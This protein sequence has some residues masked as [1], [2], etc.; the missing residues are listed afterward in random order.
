VAVR[1]RCASILLAA[2]LSTLGGAAR[3]QDAEGR[4]ELDPGALFRAANAALGAERPG[5]AIA[6]LEAL[7]DR[8]VVDAVVSFNRGLAYAARVRAGG[9]QPGD[10][11]RAAH[12][13]E[14]AREL[15]NDRALAADATSALAIV[16]SE[17]ARRRSRAGESV[18]IEHGFSLGRSIVEL[19]P[20]NV[21]AG[22]AAVMAL[23]LSAAILLRR[24]ATAPRAKVA[25]TTAASITGAL[26]LATAILAWAARDARLH[27]R[28][29]IVTTSGA[30]LLDARHL[31]M[32]GVPP[33]PE[34]VRARVLDESAGFS[35]VVIGRA[36]GYLPSSAVL[37]LAR[38]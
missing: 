17:I 33:I 6:K 7:G 1:R 20:E 5:E 35:R 28:E 18:E 25:A 37:P 8:G 15:T 14:E 19:L 26:L 11:G 31:A 13:F 16:R 21:W 10:L 4:E 9:E 27:L 22:I 32:D 29:G 38:P 2:G 24:R 30:R 34:G 36:E 12:G 3:A 23:L